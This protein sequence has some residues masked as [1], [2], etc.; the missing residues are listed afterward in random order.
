MLVDAILC[1]Q[2]PHNFIQ[3]GKKEPLDMLTM[4]G[5]TL[6]HPNESIDIHLPIIDRS[7]MMMV[8]MVISMR[9]SEG[10]RALGGHCWEMF[11]GNVRF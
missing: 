7:R 10:L 8:M 9:Q 5:T 4:C 3:L 1:L 11:K 2:S 6:Y